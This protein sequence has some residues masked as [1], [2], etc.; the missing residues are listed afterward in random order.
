MKIA[1]KL[2]E[3]DKPNSNGIVYSREELEKAIKKWNNS[4]GLVMFES[5]S[6][7][8]C[9]END[10]NRAVGTCKLSMDGD[11]VKATM[12]I[13][14][15]TPSGKKLIDK[16]SGPAKEV[17]MCLPVAQATLN[18]DRT[19]SDLSISKVVCS[20]TVVDIGKEIHPD[21]FKIVT[22]DS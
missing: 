22:D 7:P 15:D 1:A 12:D 9:W 19:V 5:Y 17:S 18:E 13:L 8:F 11:F 21:L 14:V 20:S 10:L 6:E 2:Y 3:A 4:S 16:L